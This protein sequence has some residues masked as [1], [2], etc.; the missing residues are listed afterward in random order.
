MK[1]WSG[2]KTSAFS[3][4][5]ASNHSEGEREQHDYYAT[6]PKATEILL[7]Q[8]K[9]SPVIWECACGEGH[10]SKVLKAAGYDVIS[11]D[12]IY[13]GY[14]DSEPL[15]FLHESLD[16]FDG[17][18][19]TNPPYKFAKEFAETAIETVSDGHKVAMFLKLTFLE[20]KGRK[21]L[22]VKY[23]PKTVYVSSSRLHCWKNGDAKA[24]E[25]SNAIAYVWI[26]WEKGFNGDPVI[27][28]VN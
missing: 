19:I 18:I 27:K 4:I 20:T 21:E 6:E 5:G 16:D 26:V 1:D 17:D 22:F 28:W 9:F 7:E 14:G 3:T 13:R 8:E 25:G 24:S 12:L 23:P 11:T 15:D 2:N 10:I